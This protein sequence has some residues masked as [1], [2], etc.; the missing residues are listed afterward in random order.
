MQLPYFVICCIVLE[1][2]QVLLCDD[3]LLRSYSELKIP[4]FTT[5]LDWGVIREDEIV[6]SQCR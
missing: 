5:T 4:P 3:H 6:M 2:V 1:E